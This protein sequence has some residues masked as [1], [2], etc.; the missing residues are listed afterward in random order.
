MLGIGLSYAAR[1]YEGDEITSAPPI[2]RMSDYESS[3]FGVSLTA[4][5]VERIDIGV[6]Y[7]LLEKDLPPFV[8]DINEISE[9][10]VTLGVRF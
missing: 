1:T 7:R 9:F 8:P 6:T 10:G 2:V 3:E 5:V 4:T